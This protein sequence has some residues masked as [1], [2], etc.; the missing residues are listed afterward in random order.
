[1]ITELNCGVEI[2]N[3]VPD[4]IHL[5]FLLRQDTNIAK[6]FKQLKGNSSHW[7]NENRFL[8]HRFEWQV[9]YS[10][11]SIS[12][13]HVD[14]VRRYIENQKAHHQVTSYEQELD[15][16]LN[17]GHDYNSRIHSWG[18]NANESTSKPRG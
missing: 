5:L 3:G 15:A 18:T 10:A 17:G 1:L 13:G 2:I 6:V 8:A 14:R 7:I 11:F 9:G 4:H 16:L 12:R